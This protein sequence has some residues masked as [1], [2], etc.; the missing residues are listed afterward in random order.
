MFNFIIDSFNDVCGIY[1]VWTYVLGGIICTGA[2][3]GYIPQLIS[4][5]KAEST[6]GFNE[7]SVFLLC[8]SLSTLTLNAIILNWYKWSCFS[9][10]NSTSP[11]ICLLNLL[12]VFQIG[13][14]WLMA[15]FVYILFLRFKCG[16]GGCGGGGGKK[17]CKKK[18]EYKLLSV[19]EY[20][21][22][23]SN[24][25]HQ[26]VIESSDSDLDRVD[27]DMIDVGFVIPKWILDW[28]LFGI[29]SGFVLIVIIISILEKTIYEHAPSYTFFM[30][31]AYVLG[32]ISAGSSF[33]VWIPQIIHLIKYKESE[34]LSLWMFLLQA[35]GSL[36]VIVFQ[37]IIYRQSIITWMPYAI[38]AVEQFTVVGLLIW[39]KCLNKTKNTRDNIDKV[40]SATDSSMDNDSIF[41]PFYKS[42]SINID[43]TRIKSCDEYVNEHISRSYNGGD[44]DFDMFDEEL[45]EAI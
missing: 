44:I 37:A 16:K 26:G 27:L 21:T 15:T 13:I 45:S 4:L 22:S 32:I 33:I 25:N 39:L 31:F 18:K 40:S 6:K 38:N 12:S 19:N 8:L 20:D 1:S 34:G 36:V 5:V 30:G 10:C 3:A 28:G 24:V 23:F 43:T 14:S 42:D 7:L 9:D 35:P 41:T 29:Y 17:C 11:F 2:I